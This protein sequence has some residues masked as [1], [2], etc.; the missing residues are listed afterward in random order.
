MKSFHKYLFTA[1][2]LCTALMLRNNL[3]AQKWQFEPMDENYRLALQFHKVDTVLVVYPLVYSLDKE[4]TLLIESYVFWDQYQKKPAYVYKAENLLSEADRSKNLQFYGP[5][6]SFSDKSL[7]A[8]AIQQRPTGFAFGNFEFD[9]DED[10]F[11]YIDTTATRFYTC[12]NSKKA[13]FP[14]AMLP[15]G[16]FQLSIWRSYSYQIQASFDRQSQ[17][18][19]INDLESLRNNYFCPPVKR[20]KIQL[21][22]AK[23]LGC[24]SAIENISMHATSFT[25]SLCILIGADP[26]AIPSM[27]CYFYN[28]HDELQQFLGLPSQQTVYGKS[29]GNTNHISG[30]NTD[31][32]FHETGHTVIDHGL[33]KCPNSFWHEGF[34]QFTTY[35]FSEKA[36]YNDLQETRQHSELLTTQLIANQHHAY[37]TNWSNYPV[38]GVFMAF[39]AHTVS[40]E[41]LLEA[42]RKLSLDQ[43]VIQQFESPELAIAAFRQWINEEPK[44]P[45]R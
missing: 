26:A 12:R 25:D 44:N 10:A 5:Y 34:R 39:L 37:F 43:L 14:F 17:S 23:T 4:D 40:F 9:S 24:N 11:F 6:A 3:C 2:L 13:A 8:D 28:A 36:F 16:S 32:L 30:L 31:V 7:L 1:L 35:Y 21:F 45:L 42:Y 27:Q 33:G 38:S 22:V 15:A 20:G 41:Q 18:W 19:K 29:M